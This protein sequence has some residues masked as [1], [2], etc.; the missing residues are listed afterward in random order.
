MEKSVL[1]GAGKNAEYLLEKRVLYSDYDIIAIVDNNP[2]KWGLVF[3]SY[4]VVS[5]IE[6]LSMDFEVVIVCSQYVRE[7]TEQINDLFSSKKEVISC[8]D[9]ENS[10]V[11]KLNTIYCDC[12]DPEIRNIV[13]TYRK[14]GFCLYGNYN[15]KLPIRYNVIREADGW[16][17]ILFEGKRMYYPI[18]H[19]FG[20]DN[21]GE[22]LIDVLFEQHND[23]PHLYVR[24]TTEPR[25]VVVDAGVCEGNFALRYVDNVTKLYLIECDKKWCDALSKTFEPYKDKVVICNKFLSDVDSDT[26]ITI[27]SLVKDR[28]DF[29]KMDIE[30][31]EVAALKGARR[32]LTYSKATCAVCSYH[33]YGDENKIKQI[34]N[35]YGYNTSVSKGYMFF[36]YDDAIVDTMDFR[37][38]IVYGD[39]V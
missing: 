23:S 17:Y 8:F 14:T 22:Y 26:T 29:L 31:A 37:R 6:S 18:D 24:N 21:K 2:D 38:G 1:W 5:P 12:K 32:V 27:D 10:L 13:E 16:P 15:T 25:G 36:I 39:K 28:I 7:I 34:L 4:Q 20:C 30:G 35:E 19:E 11:S 3:G 33:K 9:L